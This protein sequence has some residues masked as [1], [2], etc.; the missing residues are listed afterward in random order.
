M[1]RLEG[2]RERNYFEV[3][4]N[5]VVPSAEE[6]WESR[7]VYYRP[8]ME[9]NSDQSWVYSSARLDVLPADSDPEDCEESHLRTFANLLTGLSLITETGSRISNPVSFAA[10]VPYSR[11]SLGRGLYHGFCG[12]DPE[13]LVPPRQNVG[14]R[15]HYSGPLVPLSLLRLVFIGKTLRDVQ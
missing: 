2:V 15:L 4:W 8:S 9:L 11:T 3:V 1:P 5:V 7:S 6:F 13:T 12:W 10:G 14:F